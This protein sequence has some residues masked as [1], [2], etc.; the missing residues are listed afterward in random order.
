MIIPI[1]EQKIFLDDCCVAENDVTQ[2]KLNCI[3]TISTFFIWNFVDSL[4][5][6]SIRNRSTD[7]QQII[8]KLIQKC[9]AL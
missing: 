6:L 3:Q 5:F 4:V 1:F 7:I 2:L 8:F 9:I